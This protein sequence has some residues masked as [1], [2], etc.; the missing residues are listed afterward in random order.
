MMMKVGIN[1]KTMEIRQDEN[2]VKIIFTNNKSNEERRRDD[3]GDFYVFIK[4]IGYDG[5]SKLDVPNNNIK[6]RLWN[7]I[8]DMKITIDDK[9]KLEEKINN[10]QEAEMER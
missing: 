1:K 3:S 5:R 2:N 4:N 9:E 10:S 8:H 7:M 6:E